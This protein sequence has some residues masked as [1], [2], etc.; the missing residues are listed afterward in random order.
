VKASKKEA[1]AKGKEYNESTYWGDDPRQE[2][3]YMNKIIKLIKYKPPKKGK[4]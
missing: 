1:K 3:A 2:R 4:R